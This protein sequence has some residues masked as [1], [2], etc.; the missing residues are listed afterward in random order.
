MAGGGDA[1]VQTTGCGA[2]Q[3]GVFTVTLGTGSLIGASFMEFRGNPTGTPQMFR[4]NSAGRYMAFG[5]TGSGGGALAWLQATFF[6][7]EAAE[8][9]AKG[10]SAFEWMSEQAEAAPAG[11]DTAWRGPKRFDSALPSDWGW[12]VNALVLDLACNIDVS[13]LASPPAPTP[14]GLTDWRIL[15]ARLG[16]AGALEQRLDVGDASY[17]GV[18]AADAAGDR[19]VA[20]DTVQAGPVIAKIAPDGTELWRSPIRIGPVPPV[21][22]VSSAGVLAIAVDLEG[23]PVVIGDAAV[24]GS[25]N[26]SSYGWVTKADGATGAAVWSHYPFGAAGDFALDV[27]VDRG[28]NVLVAGG[29][30]WRWGTRKGP[31][32]AKLGPDGTLLEARPFGLVASDG[33]VAIGADAAGNA[34]VAGIAWEWAPTPPGTKQRLFD[35][36]L[37]KLDP[38]GDPVWTQ[39]FA[40]AERL[41]YVT[42]VAVDAGGNACVSGRFGGDAFVAR[43]DASGALVWRADLGAS[44][45]GGARS[46]A[47]DSLGNCYA[48]AQLMGGMFVVKLAPDGTVQ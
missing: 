4:S 45:G 47:I 44:P 32:L 30:S 36:F 26:P 39:R 1:V 24:D 16:P 10:R 23:N 6:R 3:P 13:G 29:D 48:L 11:C 25:P 15:L 12:G 9:E 22:A 17:P 34:Y 21:L 38:A 31:W 35:G 19:F 46:V 20:W 28:G 2:V 43:Y 41:V 5:G 33:V 18:V 27:A 8:A 42:D 7:E 37:A 40:D 14:W